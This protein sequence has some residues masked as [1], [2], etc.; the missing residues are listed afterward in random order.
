MS[1]E[2]HHSTFDGRNKNRKGMTKINTGKQV[3][4]Q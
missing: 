1:F 2:Q 3:G 4:S